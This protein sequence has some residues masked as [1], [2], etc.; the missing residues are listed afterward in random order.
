MVPTFG[1]DATFTPSSCGGMLTHFVHGEIICQCTHCADCHANLR[2]YL[3]IWE[4]VGQ[5]RVPE[6]P[7]PCGE[8]TR[9]GTAPPDHPTGGAKHT[10]ASGTRQG[11]RLARASGKPRVTTTNAHQSPA[12][13]NAAGARRKRPGPYPKLPAKLKELV[14]V[15]KPKLFNRLD[16]VMELDPLVK[17][18]L[19]RHRRRHFNK[20]Y[21][22]KA[23]NPGP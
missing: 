15:T 5:E 12:R 10:G 9:Q 6:S 11:A 1:E 14:L 8:P 18:E 3:S 2:A 22:Q 19:S 17:K 4:T 20:L 16:A 21:A 23:R 7:R 13:A